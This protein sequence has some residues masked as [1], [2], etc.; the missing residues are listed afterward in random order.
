MITK[1]LK[2]CALLCLL[3][4]CSSGIELSYYQ[5]PQ[6]AVAEAAVSPVNA[7]VLYVEP[8][9]VAAY[10][11]TN[12][13]ILQQSAVQLHKT[14]QHQ[15]AEALDQQLQRLLVH[16]LQQALPA[17]R[18]TAQQSPANAVRLLVQVEQFHGQQNGQVLVSGRFHL[19]SGEQSRSQSFALSLPQ[20]AEGYPAMVATLGQGWQQAIDQFAQAIQQ[21]AAKS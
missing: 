13:L 5:L 4:G 11:N 9:L 7:P 19:L 16:G 3:A 20:P 21:L 17:Y 10:L 1:G 2:T 12:A 18:V 14:S 15:W 6:P 8:L